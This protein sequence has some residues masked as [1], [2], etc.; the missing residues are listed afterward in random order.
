MPAL[1]HHRLACLLAAAAPL[2]WACGGGASGPDAGSAGDG[3]AVADASTEVGC[4]AYAS[5]AAA[6]ELFI[7]PDG[8]EQRLIGYI[9]AA[10]T[11][12]DLMMYLMTMD[13]F[14]SALVR[15][16]QRGVAVRVLLDYDHPGNDDARADLAAAGVPLRDAPAGF[17]HAHTKAM[18]IDRD[19]A[20]I[21][22]SNMNYTA[23]SDER[24]YGVVD[25]D[26]EDVADL[27]GVFDSDWAND[28][29]YPD[30]S[31][32]RLLVSPV[33]A[34]QRLL[35]HINR[36]QSALDLSVMYIADDSVRQALINRHQD[37]VTVRVLLADPTWIADNDVTA[38]ELGA[39]G[40]AVRIASSA[41][42]L[43]AKL[44]LSDGVPFIGSQNMSHTSLAQNRE[45]GVMLSAQSGAS[46]AA[47]QFT[48]D[49]NAGTAP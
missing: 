33:N 29:S 2:L 30:L 49:W 17:M 41:I 45:I 19:R 28:G 16:H 36:A 3:G 42:Q 4:G 44:V 43:H 20:V 46:Q 27:Q 8:L 14:S 24:N 15:A 34:R 9:D 7:G 40:I 38:A 13:E 21:M 39:A 23:M 37:G 35:E 32:T 31:C 12:L 26:A 11:S 6:P 25:R 48:L 1:I 22:S 47:A 18:I 5:R 10:T